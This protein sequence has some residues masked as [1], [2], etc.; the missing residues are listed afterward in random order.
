[1][2]SVIKNIY[3]KNTKGSTLRELST[4]TGK[5]EKF[6][7]QLEMF[8][9][10]TTGDTAHIDTIFKFLPH[11]LTRDQLFRPI[12]VQSQAAVYYSDRSTHEL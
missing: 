3:N 8:D 4:A 11:T 10:C 1:M 9:L 12:F 7:L 5:V 6:F 2:F